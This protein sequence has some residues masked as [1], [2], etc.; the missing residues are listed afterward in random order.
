[1]AVLEERARVV[2]LLQRTGF[3]TGAGDGGG[4]FDSAVGRVLAPGDDPDA[5]PP[6]EL[7]PL[8]M[9]GKRK[10][11]EGA[12]KAYREAVRGQREALTIWWLDRMVA[13]RRPWVE[14]RTLLW[15]DHWA[16]SIQKVKSGQ[17]M[18]A[19]NATLRRLG[20]GDFQAMARAMVKDPAL[21]L[22]L[23][24]AGN[25]AKA[26]NENLARELME[27]FVLGVG[28]YE[29]ADVRQAAAALTG[30]AVDRKGEEWQP[31]FRPRQH[32]DGAQTVLGTKTDFTAMALVDHL[33]EQP[34]CPRHVASRLWA[35][36]VSAEDGPSEESLERIAASRD[37]TRMVRAILTDPAF[38]DSGS[39]L[40]KQPVEYVVGAMRALG[41][42]PRELEKKQRRQLMRTLNGLGQVPFAPP[43]VGG[44]PHGAAWL[45]TAAAKVRIGF[46]QQLV[47]QADLGPIE[48]T[49]RGGRPEALARLL[50]VPE[51]SAATARVL[52]GAAKEPR[53]VTAI[54]LTAPEYLVLA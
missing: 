15:H 47:R 19:Q 13:T 30:W 31:R 23:D 49:A 9:R 22:W 46:A 54:A 18:L 21:M 50:G 2:R 37:L 20:G 27:L 4:G 52:D 39:V 34:A 35:R 7:G 1:M 48:R 5:P 32:A 51:W 53:R 26:P 33:V 43:N 41:V 14:K 28:H 10:G 3:S 42:R 16:T 11:D 36:L 6:P 8:P 25:T 24:A 45:T 44:W 12:K 17:A 40:V 38:S 29:E